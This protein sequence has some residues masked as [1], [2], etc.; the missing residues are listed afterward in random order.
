M[1]TQIYPHTDPEQ[2]LIGVIL[3]KPDLILSAPI[4]ARWFEQNYRVIEAMLSLTGKGINIDIFTVSKELGNKGLNTL[5]EYQKNSFANP[6]NYN[7]YIDDIRSRFEA[8]IV[9]T[10]V[11]SALSSIDNGVKPTEV[12][13]SLISASMKSTTPDSK[14]F[15]YTAKEAMSSFIDRLTEIYDTEGESHAGIMTGISSI[16]NVIGGIQKSD[17]TIVGARPAVGKTAY[18]LSVLRNLARQ[19]KKVGFFSTE[20]ASGQVMA[21]LTSL[22]TNIPAVKFR[23]GALVEED[24]PKLTMATNNMANWDL[25]I[26][27]KPVITISELTMQARAWMADGGIDFIVVD[28]L[29]R[30]HPDKSRNNQTLDVG[31]IATGLKNLARTLHI[32]VMVLA[33]LNRQSEQRTDKRPVMAD[34]RDSGVVEQEADQILLLHR[35]EDGS[36]EIIVEKNRHGATGAVR[37]SFELETMRWGNRND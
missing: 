21:R 9:R 31:D 24:F 12:L 15:N 17:M 36:P 6:K 26:C 3:M 18:G 33:Q 8:R 13:N 10:A 22:E 35:P 11:E 29:T 20:M 16:D 32:P 4:E 19:G 30:L 37:C 7:L 27:D 2:K 28:Y 14:N 34:L 1:T 25:R 5:I 23:T